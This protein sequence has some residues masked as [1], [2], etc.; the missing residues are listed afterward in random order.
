MQGAY[1]VKA[2]GT[3]ETHFPLT[4]PIWATDR[5]HATFEFCISFD[6]TESWCIAIGTRAHTA[7]EVHWSASQS[8]RLTLEVRHARS[9]HFFGLLISIFATGGSRVFNSDLKEGEIPFRLFSCQR[10]L[11]FTSPG[12]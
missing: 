2:R 7:N 5:P 1:T 11:P 10:L 9:Y 4:F 8:P 3:P 6:R 12:D